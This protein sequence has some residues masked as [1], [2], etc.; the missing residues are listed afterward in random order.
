MKLLGAIRELERLLLS[1]SVSMIRSCSTPKQANGS[2][3]PV[4]L[5]LRSA[6]NK[7]R[8]LAER[9][10]M[11]IT[12]NIDTLMVR[13]IGSIYKTMTFFLAMIGGMIFM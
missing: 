4:Q 1:I 3:M 13:C 11:D 7:K 6:R 8:N 5:G 9:T 2:S 10:K 12:R